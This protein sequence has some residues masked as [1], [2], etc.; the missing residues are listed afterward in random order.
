VFDVTS[1][2]ALWD[3]TLSAYF[4]TYDL[5]SEHFQTAGSEWPN[6]YLGFLGMWGDQEYGDEVK[7]QESFHGFHKWTG[8]PRGPKDKYLDRKDVCLANRPVCVIKK[9]L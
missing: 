5:R 2:G 7:G 9:T 1:E 6:F 3:P 4:Y 8:G